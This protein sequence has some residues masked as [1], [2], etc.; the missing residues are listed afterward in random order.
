MGVESCWKES[1]SKKTI[2][3]NLRVRFQHMVSWVERFSYANLENEP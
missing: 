3:Q 2:T 1:K